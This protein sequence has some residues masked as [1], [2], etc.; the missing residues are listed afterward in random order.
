[1]NTGE[2]NLGYICDLLEL[3]CYLSRMKI[4][5]FSFKFKQMKTFRHL[6]HSCYSVGEY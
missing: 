5:L 4:D 3:L 1:M 2:N 6:Y